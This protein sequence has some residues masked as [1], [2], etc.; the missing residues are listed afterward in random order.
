MAKKCLK[1]LILMVT[2]EYLVI[3]LIIIFTVQANGLT[4][5][6]SLCTSSHESHPIR[7]LHPYERVI[8]HVEESLY[9][10]L[11]TRLENGMTT[12]RYGTLR[13]AKYITHNFFLC[14]YNHRKESDAEVYDLAKNCIEECFPKLEVPKL[15][16]PDVHVGTCL[17]NCF[18][19]KI[20]KK[21]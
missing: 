12:H 7:L 5:P 3:G 19:E 20:M 16:V 4:T 18:E 11:K 9:D 10:C 6:L 15:E 1:K 17:F 21:N 8:G 14:M 2:M 13:F